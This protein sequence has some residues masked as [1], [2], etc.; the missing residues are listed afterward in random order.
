MGVGQDKR[1][2]F[3][4]TADSEGAILL[5]DTKDAPVALVMGM[6][7]VNAAGFFEW[8]NGAAW[9]TAVTTA[10]TLDDAYNASAGASTISVDAG[11]VTWNATGA[12]SFV[13][14]LAGCTG[15]SDGFFIEDGADYFR[16]SHKAADTLAATAQLSSFQIDSS[17]DISL[18]S[19]VSSNFT[20]S[21]NSAGAAV[22]TLRCN[23]A[24]AGTGDISVYAADDTSVRA[25]A[26]TLTLRGM[27]PALGTG[28]EIDADVGG[29]AILIGC[30]AG[31]NQVSVGG[32]GA[33]NIFVGHTGATGLT[34]AAEQIGSSISV[35][36]A[37]A[38]QIALSAI[39][40][41][42]GTATISLTADDAVTIYSTAAGV[43]LD[44]VTASN[45]TVSGA[46]LT[47]S[48]VGLDLNSTG[49]VTMDASAANSISIGCDANTGAISIGDSH[50]ARSV[51]IGSVDTTS[52]LKLQAGTGM[53]SFTDG[54]KIAGGYAG[55]FYL[56][57]NA[58]EYTTYE[59]N[60]G[61]VSLLNALNQ[62]A[63]TAVTLD[64]AYNASGGASTITFDAGDVTWN[65][66][67]AYS[68]VLG[69]AGCTGA[70][71]GFQITNGTD[72][73]SILRADTDNMAWTSEFETF[74]LNVERDI[75]I[76]SLMSVGVTTGATG[77]TVNTTQLVMDQ[78]TGYLGIGVAVPSGMISMNGEA[79]RQMGVERRTAA[80]TAGKN[81]SIGAGGAT[82][83]A[84][85]KA[86]GDLNLASG[87]STGTGSS[88]FNFYA[89]PS[90]V[91][92]IVDNAPIAMIQGTC[93]LLTLGDTTGAS[94]TTVRTGTG[95]FTC[96]AGGIFDVNAVGAVTIDS[97]GGTIG[98]GVD[99]NAFA[100]NIGTGAAARVITIGNGTGVTGVAINTGSGDFAI[101]TSQLYVDQPTGFVGVGGVPSYLLHTQQSAVSASNT[102]V[103]FAISR[104]G[105]AAAGS[106]QR[107]IGLVFHDSDNSTLTGGIAG[108]RPN[109]GGTYEGDLA[110]YANVGSSS[111]GTFADMTERMRI[112]GASGNVG[113]GTANPLQK[114]NIQS[115]ALR[116]DYVPTLSG[117]GCTLSNGGAG[118]TTNGV[119]SVKFTA[120]NSLGET[121]LGIKTPDYTVVGMEI[122]HVADAPISPDPT[123]T[124]RNVYMTRQGG[125]IWYKIAGLLPDNTTTA[126][127]INVADASLV[128][129]GTSIANTT[130]G[131]IYNGTIGTILFDAIGSVSIGGNGTRTIPA[132]GYTDILANSNAHIRLMN[133]TGGTAYGDFGLYGVGIGAAVAISGQQ[134]CG[135]GTAAGIWGLLRHSTSN[136]AGNNLSVIAGGATLLATDKNGGLLYLKPGQSTGTGSAASSLWATPVGAAGTTTN[137]PVQVLTAGPLSGGAAGTTAVGILTT[138][139]AYPLDVVG[140]VNIAEGQ[141]YRYGTGILAYAQTALH[142][143]YFG[144]AGNLTTTGEYNIAAGDGAAI[145]LGVSAHG[146]TMIGAQAG[147][148]SSTGTY[149]VFIGNVAGFGSGGAY[150]GSNY[151]VCVGYKS[152]YDIGAAAL[153]NTLIGA[154]AGENLTTGDGNVLLGYKA[155]SGITTADNKLYIANSDTGIGSVLLTGDFSTGFLGSGYEATFAPS[156]FFDIEK[157][158]A[159]NTITDFLELTNIGNDATMTDTGTAILFNQWYYHAITPAVADAGRIAV[160]TETA[161]TSAAATQDSY[162]A[163]STALGGTVAERWRIDSHGNFSNTSAAGTAYIELKAGTTAAGTAPLKFTDGST[164]ATIEQG[165]VEMY[166]S[167]LWFQPCATLIK[168]SLDGTIFSQTTAVT[169]ANVNVATT[170]VGA[171]RGD[172]ASPINLPANFFCLAGKTLRVTA[173]GYY[174]A[175]GGGGPY[176]LTLTVTLADGG[177]DT[178]MLQTAALAVTGRSNMG[179]EIQG[180]ITCYAT[181]AAG[182]FWGQGFAT[183]ASSTTAS[184]VLQMVNTSIDTNM[185]TTAAMTLDVQATWNTADAANSIT[186][187]NLIVE[188]ID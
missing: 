8:Y 27:G 145:S 109:A 19:V 103:G 79:H 144:S 20:I 150:A 5:P 90:G 127:D 89:Y 132:S 53:I 29:G 22:L 44:A 106:F 98:I 71:D 177:G 57:L 112:L 123:V 114:V 24:G 111:A 28:V 146:N 185:D 175:T 105:G 16:L 161:W 81:L 85:D 147:Y 68:F 160:V 171:G 108:I 55:A 37:G 140:D 178:V 78:T 6:I 42:A 92:G 166:K 35:N 142:N 7:R 56:A 133:I 91:A 119:H 162:M 32:A 117:A 107:G 101:N 181:G 183:L 131:Q 104:L 169:V 87:I 99:A 65:G 137:D 23:Q 156:S 180:D 9:V 61:E 130:A 141:Y 148:Y 179:W 84:T 167:T 188:A 59:A 77:F 173:R 48:G 58:A 143:Y 10:Y 116:F 153:N 120:V 4:R 86:G 33:R 115:G 126:F 163:L 54:Y 45:F 62:C 121:E 47:L 135:L 21:A 165:A 138:T 11:D 174:G 96:T 40:I 66:T 139:P 155:G 88:G 182:T 124:S 63:S 93:A 75:H 76:D 50:S 49:V 110:F 122:I 136:T 73:L 15:T 158:G 176:T 3:D 152:G 1:I 151:N 83:G 172:A 82:L 159:V 51:T 39:N 95:A 186:C 100:I 187:T 102:L 118:G 157:L 80:N 2:N 31:T 60:F 168:Q 125:A 41:G 170:L 46:A 184:D 30:N 113:F 13:V 129:V 36:T 26:G 72:F 38:H 70:A 34:L 12:F 149:N 69:L 14:N 64:E 18:D 94:A 134:L 128:T 43:S 164:L 67:G 17:D 25:V 52:V 97:S 154:L 74:D